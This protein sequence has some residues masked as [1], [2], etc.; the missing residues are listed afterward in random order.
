MLPLLF[1]REIKTGEGWGLRK[2]IC[3]FTIWQWQK[4]KSFVSS[5]IPP[6][7]SCVYPLPDFPRRFGHSSLLSE[8]SALQGLHRFPFTSS[9]LLS[10]E[11]D[12]SG[13]LLDFPTR[14]KNAPSCLITLFSKREN[15]FS[16]WKLNLPSQVEIFIGF[17]LSAYFLFLHRN[18]GLAGESLLIIPKTLRNPVWEKPQDSVTAHTISHQPCTFLYSPQKIT[19]EISSY[20]QK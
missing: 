16:K 18:E 17:K 6:G 8:L 20:N 10:P 19:T 14:S 15:Q 3:S 4:W 2:G 7:R 1:L 11:N 9:M 13:W 5:Q 12:P